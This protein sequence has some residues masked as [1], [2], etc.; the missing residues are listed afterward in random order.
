M[1]NRMSSVLAQGVLNEI[2]Q[3]TNVLKGADELFANKKIPL[4]AFEYFGKSLVG[5]EPPSEDKIKYWYSV[6]QSPT[7]EL[8]VCTDDT[9]TEYLFTVPA[10]MDTSI[11]DLT[12]K[13][14]DFGDI[15]IDFASSNHPAALPNFAAQLTTEFGRSVDLDRVK[16]V[17]KK[18]T[19]RWTIIRNYFQC[20][21]VQVT[22]KKEKPEDYSFLQ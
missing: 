6:A 16:E 20:S 11:V 8:D 21:E 17:A 14:R 18:N 22:A 5:L 13:G 9:L 2:A 1:D 19:E 12:T 15:V 4:Y 7:S 3:T 10:P